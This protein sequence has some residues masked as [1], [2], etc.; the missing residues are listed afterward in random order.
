MPVELLLEIFRLVLVKDF[1]IDT[2]GPIGAPKLALQRG[3]RTRA[4]N[5]HLNVVTST[6][7]SLLAVSRWFRE[8]A[9]EVFWKENTFRVYART[10]DHAEVSFTGK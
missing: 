9:R 5:D 4:R 1:P 7:L 8:I 2:H 6:D 3:S 10:A